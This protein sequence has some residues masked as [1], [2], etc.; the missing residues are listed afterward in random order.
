MH[1][2]Q[3]DKALVWSTSPRWRP[4]GRRTWA[5]CC[6]AT[7]PTE[8]TG[9]EAVADA[10]WTPLYRAW[11]PIQRRQDVFIAGTSEIDGARWVMSMG[12]LLGVFRSDWLGIRKTHKAVTLR[13]AE[14]NSVDGGRVVRSAFF[15]DIIGVMQQ[16]GVHPLPPQT[17]ASTS[18]SARAPS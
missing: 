11:S 8:L 6:A 3:Q 16:A 10:L 1:E 15:C 2:H 18:S 12:H 9:V 7:P 17:G 13:Y 5:T 4:R 14:F